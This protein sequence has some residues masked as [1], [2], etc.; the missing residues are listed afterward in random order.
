VALKVRFVVNPKAGPRRG[1]ARLRQ[2]LE[3]AAQEAGLDASWVETR[4]R[5]DAEV[6]AREAALAGVPLVAAA[7]GDGTVNEVARG[8]LGGASALGIIPLG[9]GNG[10]ARDLGISLDPERACR[11]LLGGEARRLDVGEV[12]GH[13]F[14]MNA[15]FGIDALVSHEFD[16]EK[17][18]VRG[19]LPYFTLTARALFGY[20][21][22]RL[23]I[24]AA[25]IER[26]VRPLLL[27]AANTRQLG[28]GAFV[29][30]R[31]L[32][33]D[34]LLDLVCVP[35]LPRWRA[36]RYAVKLFA[37]N[38]YQ[39][40]EVLVLREAELTVTGEGPI[41]A[42]VDGEPLVLPSQVTI[43]VHRRAL[44]VWSPR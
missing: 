44:P 27:V 13:V 14:L 9:S 28:G 17:R 43:R 12:D 1:R 6:L 39:A 37:G 15:G 32:P 20:T 22:P 24:G 42:Q 4:A 38:L 29:A 7:G 35:A 8:L 41:L 21:P 31:A 3:A 36:V 23:V 25:G 26:E 33:D 18:Q 40:P 30:P 19:L 5:G 34:G 11:Q 2:R 10:L 16:R